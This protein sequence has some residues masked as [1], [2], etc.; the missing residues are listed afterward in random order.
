LWLHRFRK[1][2]IM[3]NS[4]T[5]K[6]A[7]PNDDDKP[8]DPAVEAVRR[9]LAR[10]LAVSISI[11]MVG[12]LAVLGAIV[13]RLNDRAPASQP[14]AAMTLPRDARIIGEALD[15]DRILLRLQHP[16]GSQSIEI[17]SATDGRR[18]TRF[19]IALEP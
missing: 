19:T 15:G 6:P 11:M 16:D 5:T 4:A 8:L 14:E 3:T 18:I 10:L 2:T 1:P 13:Y 12:L 9:R 7:T 17:H